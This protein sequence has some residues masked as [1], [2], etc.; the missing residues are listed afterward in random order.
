MTK[1]VGDEF[2]LYKGKSNFDDFSGYRPSKGQQPL[3]LVEGEPDERKG[4]KKEKGGNK[5]RK[6]KRRKE[7]REN[8]GVTR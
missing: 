2:S 4:Q 5:G 3:Q 7:G 8:R 1:V 6:K